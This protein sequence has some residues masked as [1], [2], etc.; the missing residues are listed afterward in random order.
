MA[1]GGRP[2][3]RSLRAGRAPSGS[4]ARRARQPAAGAAVPPRVADGWAA[5]ASRAS[6]RAR[7]A[8][9]PRSRGR[10]SAVAAARRDDVRAACAPEVRSDRPFA[11]G[12]SRTLGSRPRAAESRTRTSSARTR[13]VAVV[14]VVQGVLSDPRSTVRPLPRMEA[15]TPLPLTH[16]YVYGDRARVD[17][18]SVDDQALVRLVRE[19]L[20]AGDDPAKLVTDALE[21]AARVLDR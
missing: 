15:A 2:R 21:I 7:L 20:D 19:R 1:G 16:V 18:R 3:G 4:F 6:R 5:H 17:G 10:R 14:R 8:G 12:P 11:H 9:A 13:A